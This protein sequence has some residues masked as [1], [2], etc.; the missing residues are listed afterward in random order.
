ML[1]LVILSAALWEY[2]FHDTILAAAVLLGIVPSGLFLMITVAYGSAAI[3]LASHDALIQQT[4]AV[5]SLSNVDIFCMD[6]TGTLTANKFALTEVQPITGDE[7]TARAKLGLF[8]RSASGGNKTSEAIA[9]ACPGKK[10]SVR[11]E[12]T[13]SSAR[14]WS[15]ISVDAS[16]QPG[17]FALGA[18]E[19]LG[20]LVAGG[21]SLRP[22]TG[23]TESGYR[24]LL[25]AFSPDVT[26][27]HDA[28]GEPTLPVTLAPAA[29]LGITD[30][31]R[32]N[33]RET[34]EAFRQGGITLKIISGDNPETVAALA[35]QA[36]FPADL[37]RYSGLELANMSYP[38]FSQAASDGTIFGRITPE[39]T[40][41]LVRALRARGHY[42]AMTGDGVNDVLSLKQAN[43]GIAMQSG[44][45]ATCAA[46]DVVLLN[47]SFGALP[48]AFGEGQRIRRG[49]QG[50]FYLFLTRVFTVALI[51][52]AIAVIEA[53]FPFSPGHISL[54]TLLTVAVPT[55][56][57]T[58]MA[59]P[60]AAPSRPLRSM[61]RFV[62]PATVL[63]STAAFGAYVLFY[64]LRD[65]DL[66]AARGGVVAL[67]SVTAVDQLARDALTFVLV[68]GGLWLVVFA[69]PPTRFWAVVEEN[70]NDWRSTLV[71][72]AMLGVYVVIMSVPWLRG[73]FGVHHL[74][75]G[76]Y[77]VI[78]L[79]VVG[80]ALLLRYVWKTRVFDRYFGY[81]EEE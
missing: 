15:A 73:F 74:T 24:V 49:L 19:M 12:I 63:L 27:L 29:W 25:F 31:L 61:L 41:R 35:C 18:P 65:I 55:F 36:G 57:L 46:A 67:T 4:N 60:G 58:F 80:W 6:K 40:E 59:R 3:R 5:E 33:S 51:I 14:K 9:A 53:G 23:W 32:P 22:P 77:L 64:F 34:L 78:A 1:V 7:A 56:A 75:I 70:P 8:A 43:L 37:K 13:F 50:I 79:I 20:P 2:P 16:D 11:D 76:D 45:Q 54:L 69:A 28:T 44:S 68:L 81:G 38:E 10:A 17:V 42:V 48:A 47:D 66:P 26:L 30:E 72:A 52:T 62:L 71:A 39:Q 21:E